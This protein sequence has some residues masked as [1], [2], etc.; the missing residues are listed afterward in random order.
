MIMGFHVKKEELS[1]FRDWRIRKFF[2]TLA[3]T[4]IRSNIKF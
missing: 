2:E 4:S 3:N 1:Y